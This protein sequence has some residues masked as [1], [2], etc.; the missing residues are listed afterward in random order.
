[1]QRLSVLILVFLLCFAFAHNYVQAQEAISATYSTEAEF[2]TSLTFNLNAQSDSNIT[3]IIL[4]YK[5]DKITTVTVISE[6]EPDFYIGRTVDTSW[7]WDMHQSGLPPGAKV[8]Y[9]WRIEDAAGHE[10]KTSWEPAQFDD[11]R[12]NWISLTEDKITLYWYQ[13]DQAFAQELLDT[14]KEALEK[15][16]LDTGASLER[17][18]EIYIYANSADLQGALIYPQEWTGGMSFNEYGI[19]AIGIDTKNLAWGK[20]IIAHELAHLV[21]YQMTYNPYGDIPTWLSE[22]LSMYAEGA[23]EMSFQI[24]LN[25][26]I[27]KDS[28]ISVQSVSS[29]FPTNEKEARLS[30]AQSYG[31]VEFLINEYGQEKMLNLLNVFKQ[32]STYDD[33]LMTIYGFDTNGLDDT[34]RLSLGL[35]PRE[36]STTPVPKTTPKTGFLDCQVI[37]TNSSSSGFAWVGG[38]GI[39]LL[40]AIGELVRLKRRG[41]K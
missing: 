1:M 5:I 23:L 3:R 20:R 16:M 25:E 24:L 13:R 21:T 34:W 35:E 19:L 9:R 38:L 31:I 36:A 2:P 17:A 33:A 10:F 27:S 41:K 11:N 15:L 6:V 4:N 18:V 7:T 32:G 39:L 37:S 30:Y 22:G 12:Y 14:A 40:P 26:A 29:A 28:L 8:Q